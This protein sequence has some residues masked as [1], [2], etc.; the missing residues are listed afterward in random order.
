VA[1]I[2]NLQAA[3]NRYL[4]EHNAAPKLFVWTKP[5]ND[6]RAG[7]RQAE[8]LPAEVARG[9]LVGVLNQLAL[10][11]AFIR[12]FFSGRFIIVFVREGSPDRRTYYVE[13][14]PSDVVRST[15]T[16]CLQ[17]LPR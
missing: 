8:D 16:R 3:I 5:A 14:A 12:A 15:F 4:D 17:G 2:V 1:S 9:Q 6:K 10:T 7:S 11:S 13:P